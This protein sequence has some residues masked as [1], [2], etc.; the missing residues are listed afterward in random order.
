M[1]TCQPCHDRGKGSRQKQNKPP[2][3]KE[4]NRLEVLM[5]SVLDAGKE[6][7]ELGDGRGGDQM[8]GE[9]L[10]G[11]REE[12]T[13]HSQGNEKPLEG[14]TRGRMRCRSFF[15]LCGV[16]MIGASQPAA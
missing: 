9:G 13:F 16:E 15:L 2:R 6:R 7:D 3:P 10:G 14:L 4:R 12:F 1:K 8:M 11:H 5:V